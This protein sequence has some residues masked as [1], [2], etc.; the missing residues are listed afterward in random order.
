L[1]NLFPRPGLYSSLLCGWPIKT[2]MESLRNRESLQ[3]RKLLIQGFLVVF[4][5]KQVLR[6][7]Y[8]RHHVFVNQYQISVSQ[9]LKRSL[10]CNHNSAVSRFTTYHQ[11]FDRCNMASTSSAA[12]NTYPSGT[13]E[14]T[15][16]AWEKM[17][18]VRAM[19]DVKLRTY[20]NWL[21]GPGEQKKNCL[22]NSYLYSSDHNR[23][24]STR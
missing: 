15:C 23:R 19:T 22:S 12:G 13:P 3:T 24:L 6:K 18:C 5:L 1:L 11:A 9:K 10:C 17:R 4:R 14:F 21:Y 20:L 2:Y 16:H 8:I 7:C